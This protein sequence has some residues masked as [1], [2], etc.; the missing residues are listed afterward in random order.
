LAAPCW[1]Q[2][3]ATLAWIASTSRRVALAL[4]KAVSNT[5]D[6]IG[7]QLAALGHALK[8][9]FY[10]AWLQTLIFARASAKAATIASSWIAAQSGNSRTRV[11]AAGLSHLA[12]SPHLCPRFVAGGFRCFCLDRCS[13]G[14]VGRTSYRAL[15]YRAWLEWGVFARASLRAASV[16]SAWAAVQSATLAHKLRRLLYR[17]WLEW[18]IF[19]RSAFKAASAES[20]RAA[21]RSRTFARAAAKI[22]GRRIVLGL[23]K[24]RRPGPG[25]T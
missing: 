15:L 23:A 19:T 13:V 6:W 1:G 24:N 5:G 7:V 22:G 18:R 3:L 10:R 16:A 12:A 4:A 14:C 17:T 20:A 9:W 8:R 25:F 2:R 11:A 21:K